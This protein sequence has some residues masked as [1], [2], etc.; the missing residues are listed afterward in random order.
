MNIL[1]KHMFLPVN[2][3]YDNLKELGYNKE[4][5]ILRHNKIQSIFINKLRSGK[6]KRN[7]RKTYCGQFIL[8]GLQE[9]GCDIKNVLEIIYI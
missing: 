6:W 9:F 7:G 5:S 4:D 1:D 2:F 8:E 3:P